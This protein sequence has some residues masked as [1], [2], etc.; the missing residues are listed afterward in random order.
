MIGGLPTEAVSE[1]VVAFP[2]VARAMEAGGT[3]TV[4]TDSEGY[5]VIHIEVEAEM[6]ETGWTSTPGGQS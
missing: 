1:L 5:L 6:S 2:D 4:S 3:L